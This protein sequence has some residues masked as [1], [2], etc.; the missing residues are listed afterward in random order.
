VPTSNIR[1][2]QESRPSSQGWLAVHTRHQ[3]EGLAARSLACKG[4]DTFLPQ[5]SSV[6]MWSDRSKELSAPLFPGYVF[7]RNEPEHRFRIVTTPGVLN[8]VGFAGVPAVIPDSEIEA[9]RQTLGRRVQL[10]PYPFLNSGDWVRVKAGPL[11]GI[12]GILV[13]HKKLFRLV[14][15]V[16][17]LQRSAS[18]EVDACSVERAPRHIRPGLPTSFT[19]S[20]CLCR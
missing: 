5:Y 7:L 9:V 16:Q 19:L 12:E 17:L 3:H 18:V 14:L 8:L 4:F 2:D 20:P 1:L 10:A 6:R 13:R 11:E 15:S